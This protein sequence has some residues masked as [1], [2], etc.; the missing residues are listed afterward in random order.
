MH[1]E[2]KQSDQ[3][4]RGAWLSPDAGPGLP[5]VDEQASVDRSISYCLRHRNLEDVARL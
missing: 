5:A 1:Q 4:P 2:A 3:K